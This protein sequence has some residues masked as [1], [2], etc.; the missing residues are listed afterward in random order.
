MR[1]DIRLGPTEKVEP[2][3]R[4]QKGEAFPRHFG[5]TLAFE[6][7]VEPLAQSMQMQHIGGGVRLLR[8]TQRALQYI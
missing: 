8:L 4:R 2:R 1:E 5:P 3:P 7:A 6:H